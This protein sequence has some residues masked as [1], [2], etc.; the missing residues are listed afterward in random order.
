MTSALALA[1]ASLF[2]ATAQPARAELAFE[3]FPQFATAGTT[4]LHGCSSCTGYGVL[5]ASFTLGS[6][7]TLDQALV[8]IDPLT[9]PNN[10][11]FTVSIMA[12]N[13]NDLP[14]G[15][16]SSFA[17]LFFQDYTPPGSLTPEPG[18]TVLANMALPNWQL[19]AGKYWIR[20]AGY[21][22]TLPIYST[23]TPQTSRVVG[24]QFFNGNGITRNAPDEAIGFSLNALP[25]APVPEPGRLALLCT[26]LGWLARRRATRT[27]RAA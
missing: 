19:A 20:F 11:T 25:A 1:A 27:A 6:A 15:G 26:G 12:D 16:D 9:D 14:L 18:G 21:A 8:L 22:M 5:V 3:S 24:G 23:A 13:G 4:A 17:P 2:L 7:K 10:N